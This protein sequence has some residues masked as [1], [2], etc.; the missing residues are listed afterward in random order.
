MVTYV[1]ATGLLVKKYFYSVCENTL[2][3]VAVYLAT[4]MRLFWV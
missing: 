3:S 2:I 4:K 1:I